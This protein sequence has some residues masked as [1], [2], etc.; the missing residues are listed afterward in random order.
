MEH[1]EQNTVLATRDFWYDLPEELIA[2]TPLEQR[3][4]ARL[5]CLNR[6]TGEVN[7]K[8]FYDIIDYLMPGDCLVMNDS[9]GSAC[10]SSGPQTHRRRSGSAAA[11]GSGQQ[12]LG[13]PVQARPED[14]GGQ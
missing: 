1:N 12:V 14:A 10:P 4:T 13:V 9:P 3:D 6:V 8:H 7:H 5:M 11:A 2:Q